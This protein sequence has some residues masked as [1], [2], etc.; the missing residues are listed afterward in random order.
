MGQVIHIQIPTTR[1]I[2]LLLFSLQV[3]IDKE[4][5]LT[6]TIMFRKK[7]K[8]DFKKI[9]KYDLNITDIAMRMSFIHYSKP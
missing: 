2:Q 7:D 3:K 5:L 6:K 1:S 9:T 8:P 4:Y